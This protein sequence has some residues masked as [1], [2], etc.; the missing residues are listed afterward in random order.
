[1]DDTTAR[2][3]SARRSFSIVGFAFAALIV[4]A[5][6]AQLA[7]MFLPK[8]LGWDALIRKSWWTWVC[9]S[10]P[11]YLFAFPACFLGLRMLPAEAPQ[12]KALTVKQFFTLLPICFCMMYAGNLVG[13]LLSW[14][15]SGGKAVNALNSYAMD[16]SPLKILVMVILAPLLEELICRKLLI[17]R[18]VRYGEKL[19]VLMSG[20]IFG[21]LHQN[22]FQFFYAFALGGLFA[23]VYIRTGRIRYTVILHTIINFMGAVVA[24]G[25]LSLLN[26]EALN[27]LASGNVSKELLMEVLPG[28][29]VLMGYAAALLGIS[30]FGLVL[31]IL[32]FR[33]LTWQ[34]SSHQLLKKPAFKA[35][36]LNVGMI[37]YTAI[38]LV[39]IVLA[40]FNI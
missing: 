24:P 40:L 29:L 5:F 10:A 11:M 30:I 4:V 12:R 3:H 27:E 26:M 33:K 22:L 2:L 21:L 13:N 28:Y 7:F 32:K 20:L 17:D 8:M 9:A 36:F 25:I 31:L 14:V 19:S 37:V 38:C 35:A 15:L 18:T 23:Y 6:A 1:M 39:M 34:E 16:Q